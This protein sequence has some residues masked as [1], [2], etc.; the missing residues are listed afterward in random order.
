MTTVLR[1]LVL[2]HVQSPSADP[3]QIL[4]TPSQLDPVEQ[5]VAGSQRHLVAWVAGGARTARRDGQHSG[6]DL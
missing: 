5:R 1:Q 4:S 3:G 6:L 2:G